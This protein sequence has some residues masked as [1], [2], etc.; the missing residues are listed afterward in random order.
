MNRA[1]IFRRL[2][3]L[4]YAAMADAPAQR[5]NVEELSV[6]ETIHPLQR[7]E[8]DINTLNRIGIF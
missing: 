5:R 4:S 7:R 3:G 6:V 1:E 2:F 8:L